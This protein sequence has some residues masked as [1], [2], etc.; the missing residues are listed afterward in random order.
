MSIFEMP[1]FAEECLSEYHNFLWTIFYEL[2]ATTGSS[3]PHYWIFYEVS[4][5]NWKT[6]IILFCLVILGE[7]HPELEKFTYGQLKCEVAAWAG[8]LRNAGVCKGDVV[9]GVLPNSPQVFCCF[10]PC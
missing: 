1:F 9:A 2:L 7:G 8:A 4:Y 5:G 6:W 10:K 3:F